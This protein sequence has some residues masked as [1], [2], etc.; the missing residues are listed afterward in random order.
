MR[1]E[2]PGIETMKVQ[3]HLLGARTSSR[4]ALSLASD[5]ISSGVLLALSPGSLELFRQ[6]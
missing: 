1:K 2:L 6:Y 3:K 4:I 5:T